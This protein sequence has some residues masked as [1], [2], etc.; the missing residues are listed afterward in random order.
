MIHLNILEE[1]DNKLLD[2]KD[3][4]LLLEHPGQAT[5]K[6]AEVEQKIAE[7]FKTT[8]EHVE[9]IYIFSVPGKPAS[10]VKAKVWSK[11]IK[12]EEVKDEAQAS[13]EVGDDKG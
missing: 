13:Q 2:R 3:L 7:H 6:K 1:H 10:R 12:K 11:P 9:V 8:P 4:L 5:P